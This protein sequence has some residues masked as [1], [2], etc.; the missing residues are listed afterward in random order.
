MAAQPITNYAK[1]QIAAQGGPPAI[2]ERMRG[3]ETLAE[4]AR[5]FF[6]PDGRAIS[7]RLLDGIMGKVPGIRAA[8]AQAKRDFRA[9][10]EWPRRKRRKAIRAKEAERIARAKLN[11]D[12]PMIETENQRTYVAHMASLATERR[13]PYSKPPVPRPT[14]PP[15][16]P[17]PEP[18]AAPPPR[19][20]GVDWDEHFQQHWCH[21]CE[22]R[23]CKHIKREYARRAQAYADE[24][25]RFKPFINRGI[26]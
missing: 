24:Q 21:D 20:T 2:V 3:G 9:L 10:P 16:V 22:R 23:D 25:N 6:R 18:E 17:L 13:N 11:L 8:M 15:P 12:R 14:P 5:T 7:K 19:R 4:I 1:K 26:V